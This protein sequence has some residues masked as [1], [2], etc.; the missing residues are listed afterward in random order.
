MTVLFPT[1][2]EA[3]GLIKRLKSLKKHNSIPGVP[4]YTG[5]IEK[6]SVMVAII[7]IG[8]EMSVKNTQ[9]LFQ[10]HPSPIVILAGFAGALTEDV[11]K[12][13]ILIARDYSNMA[14]INYIRLVPGFDIAS[15][16]PVKQTIAT[17]NEKRHL[18]LE[19]GCQM[20]DMETAYLSNLL[21]GLGVEFMSVRTI[22]DLVN[23]D[24][25]QDVLENGYDMVES[26]TTPV[27]MAKYLI[28]NPGRIKALREFLAPLPEIRD[29]LGKFLQDVIEEV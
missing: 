17:A 20:V 14:L 28:F 12:G 2:F 5:K 8:P 13:Q 10:Q 22:S 11:T 4:I 21:V 19:T 7:G 24:I 29:D 26:K 9:K 18:G 3:Q 1:L 6:K 25:P 16:H 27:K 15:V 23:E